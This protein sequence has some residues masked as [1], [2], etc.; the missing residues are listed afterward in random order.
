ME[1][2]MKH[3][4]KIEQY[5]LIPFN[6]FYCQYYMHRETGAVCLKDCHVITDL[7]T[8]EEIKRQLKFGY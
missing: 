1:V 5:V 6:C 8:C 4:G 7:T 2:S 3:R